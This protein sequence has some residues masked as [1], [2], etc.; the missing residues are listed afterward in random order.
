MA[1]EI[2]RKETIKPSSPTA[3]HLKIF[4]LSFLDQ[5]APPVYTS[6]VLFYPA[7]DKTND[8]NTISEHLKKSLSE[9]LTRFPQL[10][11][12]IDSKDTTAIECTDDGAPYFE[13]KLKGTDLSSFVKHPS[14]EVLERF[15]PAKIESAD[16]S[17]G[18]LLLV[19]ATFF[20]SGGLAIGICISH[21]FA[22]AATLSI[23]LKSW[24]RGG[25]LAEGPADLNPPSDPPLPE[26]QN[27]PNARHD[28]ISPPDGPNYPLPGVRGLKGKVVL[29]TEPV[30]KRYVFDKSKIDALKYKAARDGSQQPTEV[31]VVTALVLK[32]AINASRSTSKLNNQY[33][34]FQLVDIRKRVKPP[35]PENST[36]NLVG[37]SVVQVDYNKQKLELRSLVAI[38]RKETEEF[39]EN[40]A[41]RLGGDGAAEVVSEWTK[42]VEDLTGRD[43]VNSFVCDSW[44]NYGFYEVDFGLGRPIWASRPSSSLENNTFTLMD[45]KESGGVEVRLTLS[46]ENMAAFENDQELLAYASNLNY[47]LALVEDTEKP[48]FF[49]GS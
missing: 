6:L 26:S 29:K 18:P 49:K 11:G 34:L 23:F 36:G 48:K 39:S 44:V 43:D 32:C 4:K 30:S 40:E 24:A 8:V 42:K 38:L 2:V 19:Q 12:R 14:E 16:A 21:K 25:Y 1:V 5:I 20:D 31:E 22:D 17:T 3:P 37:S 13:A 46:K 15:I 7:S 41:K 47:N 28:V 10:A 27:V 35:F 45:T 9:A 33:V